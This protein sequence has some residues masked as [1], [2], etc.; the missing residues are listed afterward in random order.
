MAIS[1][2]FDNTQYTEQSFK[3]IPVG[4]HRVRIEKAEEGVSQAGNQKIKLTLEV[5][6]HNGKLFHDF[7]FL[8]DRPD[9]TNQKLGEL[10][11]SFD[12]QPGNFN[13]ASWIGKVGAA[14][15]KHEAYN[16][17]NQA[18]VWYF[19]G[20]ERQASLPAWQ[21]PSNKAAVTGQAPQQAAM[22]VVE[23]N[24]LPWA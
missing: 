23:T 1:W 13:L 5:S 17:E 11:N 16:G 21:E 8:T 24:N 10:F 19:I 4:E 15:V 18:K 9:I 20:K 12:I 22:P 3:P 2:N 6:G 7:T 14:K